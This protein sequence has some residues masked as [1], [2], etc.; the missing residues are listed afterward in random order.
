MEF[1]KKYT[2]HP[3]LLLLS[4]LVLFCAVVWMLV[5]A[6]TPRGVLTVAVL[7]VGQGDALYIESPTGL[8][9]L[10]DGGQGNAVLRQLPKV[11]PRFDRSIDLVLETHPDSDHIGGF[12][13][14]LK[15]YHVDAFVSPGIEKDTDTARTLV[16]TVSDLHIP[17]YT[18]QRGMVLD[19]GGG[20]VLEVL[21]PD[22]DVSKLASQFANSGCVVLRLTYGAIAMLFACDA[23]QEV[24][25][26]LVLLEGSNLASDVLKVAHHGSKYSSTEA[27]IAAVRPAFAAISVGAGNTYGHPTEQTLSRL[28][29]YGTAVLRT[30]QE[31]TFVFKSDGKTLWHTR[32]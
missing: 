16:R 11:M 30:D 27:F 1:L 26:R 31:G 6:A 9:M 5:F 13:D 3:L 18:A 14:V 28:A 24:E 21:Y 12:A 8:Q 7:D 15:R 2:N 32:P 25:E 4:A 22:R 29:A 23:P 19:M 20:V 17:H 10:I